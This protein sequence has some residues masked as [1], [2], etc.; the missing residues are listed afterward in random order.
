[1]ESKKIQLVGRLKECEKI[2]KN[3]ET[4]ISTGTHLYH[5]D[6]ECVYIINLAAEGASVL[7]SKSFIRPH[8]KGVS[9]SL[10]AG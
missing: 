6:Q 7:A 9:G 3:E 10:K 1:M 5:S 2:F 8:L 4:S